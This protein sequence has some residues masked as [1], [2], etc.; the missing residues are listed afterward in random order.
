MRST[1]AVPGGEFCP[2]TAGRH[3][4]LQLTANLLQPWSREAPLFRQPCDWLGPNACK[5]FGAIDPDLLTVRVP[6]ADPHGARNRRRGRLTRLRYFNAE[7]LEDLSRSRRS[8]LIEALR[9]TRWWRHEPDVF[10]PGLHSR[11]P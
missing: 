10:H 3:W 4:D 5:E 11:R 6:C 7:L 9:I 1:R 2:M 8:D